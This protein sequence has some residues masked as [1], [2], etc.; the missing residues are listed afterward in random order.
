V[1]DGAGM[2]VVSVTADVLAKRVG[3]GKL[4]GCQDAH[5]FDCFRERERERGSLDTGT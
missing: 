5:R 3:A 2:E 1:T 4:V